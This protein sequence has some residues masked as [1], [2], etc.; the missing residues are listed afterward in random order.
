MASGVQESSSAEQKQT[1][2]EL[3]LLQV[4]NINL[5]LLARLSSAFENIGLNGC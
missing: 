1:R 2:L 4:V 3:D 5:Y